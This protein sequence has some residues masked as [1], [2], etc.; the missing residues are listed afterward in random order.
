MDQDN[1]IMKNQCY[2]NGSLNIQENG[3][4]LSEIKEE[5][6]P[7]PVYDGQIKDDRDQL[8]N[9]DIDENQG[10]SNTAE[11]V[12]KTH[13]LKDIDSVDEGIDPFEPEC[14]VQIK[15]DSDLDVNQENSAET[16]NEIHL[17][18][19]IE[20]VH[21]GMKKK[22]KCTICDYETKN[23]AHLKI[24]IESVHEGIKPIKCS[25]CTFETGNK[26]NLKIHIDSEKNRI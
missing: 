4:I 9:S 5:M 17:S 3:T 14:I 8:D 12:N 25:I 19:H 15:D 26:T 13:L 7:M 16:V 22:F 2:F 10:N 20:P 11:T 24:H 6:D 21:D 1:L 23:K 18:K